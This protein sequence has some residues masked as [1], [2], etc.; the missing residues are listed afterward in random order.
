M[1]KDNTGID[2]NKPHIENADPTADNDAIDTAG[3]GRAFFPANIW[4]RQDQ[5]Q[6]WMCL[7]NEIGAAVWEEIS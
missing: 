6:A 7:N 1:K 5:N 3:T 2:Y 4:I